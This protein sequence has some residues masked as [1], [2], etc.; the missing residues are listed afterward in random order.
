MFI[1]RQTLPVLSPHGAAD[2]GQ[3]KNAQIRE[4]RVEYVRKYAYGILY[5]EIRSSMACF[6]VVSKLFQGI[7]GLF[8][9]ATDGR[10]A[11]F[12]PIL[13]GAIL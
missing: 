1:A 8:S 7:Q 4:P 2:D 3:S 5:F 10:G 12:D 9:D 6:K 11:P 13:E